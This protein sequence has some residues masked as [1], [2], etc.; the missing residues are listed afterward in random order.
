MEKR[1]KEANHL[2]WEL[3]QY[4]SAFDA[5]FRAFKDEEKDEWAANSKEEHPSD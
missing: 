3:W 4:P 1:R 2:S 5:F